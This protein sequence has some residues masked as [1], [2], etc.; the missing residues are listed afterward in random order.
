MKRFT[1][2]PQ[3]VGTVSSLAML[4]AVVRQPL[5]K[6]V[7]DCIEARLDALPEGEH[8][9]ALEL[10]AKLERS[11]TPVIVTLREGNQ[12][13]KGDVARL[14]TFC[15]ALAVV[16]Y[17]DIEDD[18]KLARAVAALARKG[19]KQAIISYH[20][21][22]Q[23]PTLPQLLKVVD[24]AVRDGAA[25][26]K[27]ATMVNELADHAVLTGLLHARPKV[28]LAV[29]GMGAG[30][31]SLRAYLPAAGSLLAYGFLGKSM[32]PGQLPCATLSEILRATCPPYEA[33]YRARTGRA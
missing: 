1:Q 13:T 26:V 19:K 2:V 7:A 31:I 3:I 12:W 10:C 28:K 4:A 11:G 14:E 23:T 5:R 27:L 9:K 6:R 32:A 33:Q 8:T 24:K 25:V 21:F 30:G 16:T 15:Q 29:L 20:D 18:S 22:K 17:V